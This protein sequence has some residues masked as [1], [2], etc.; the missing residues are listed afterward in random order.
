[1]KLLLL[2][3]CFTI[4]CVIFFAFVEAR[5]ATDVSH[6]DTLP[7]YASFRVGTSVKT[8]RRP[9]ARKY[10]PIVG[11]HR[12]ITVPNFHSL[13]T[14]ESLLAVSDAALASERKKDGTDKDDGE[15]N[16]SANAA[17]DKNDRQALQEMLINSEGLYDARHVSSMFHVGRMG[18]R[19]PWISVV[20][21]P[22]QKASPESQAK[23]AFAG[24]IFGRGGNKKEEGKEIPNKI[25][26]LEE[27]Q[28]FFDTVPSPEGH[29][30]SSVTKMTFASKYSPKPV[31]MTLEY[32]WRE[33]KSYNPELA[34]SVAGVVAIV[35]VSVLAVV[36]LSGR[37]ALKRELVVKIRDE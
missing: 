31:N 32:I 28:I 5:I 14:E 37:D 33:Q 24:T 27:L 35:C 21:H 12:V 8:H 10:H 11:V 4:F 26:Y 30:T 36:M 23:A 3:C 6:G 25:E 19:T 22:I 20:R 16:P 15:D 29:P 1:M 9:M 34:I 13:A 7:L 18:A 2:S 17:A